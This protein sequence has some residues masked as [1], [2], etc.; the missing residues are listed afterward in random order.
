[1]DMTTTALAEVR[2]TMAKAT[3]ERGVLTMQEVAHLLGIAGRTLSDRLADPAFPLR[4]VNWSR[5]AKLFLRSDV[6]RVLSGQ[7]RTGRRVA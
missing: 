3:T 1:M 7:R 5:K 6:D 2:I 4:P